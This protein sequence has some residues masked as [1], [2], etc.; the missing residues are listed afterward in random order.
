MTQSHPQ[1]HRLLLGAATGVFGLSLLYRLFRG[2]SPQGGQ[3][4]NTLDRI[5][6]LAEQIDPVAA[7]GTLLALVAIWVILRSNRTMAQARVAVQQAETARRHVTAGLEAIDIGI[8]LYDSDDRLVLCN[9]RYRAFLDLPDVSPQSG[10]SR[11]PLAKPTA[12]CDAATQRHE[13]RSGDGRWLQVDERPTSAG[14]RIR[15]LIDITGAKSREQTLAENQALFSAILAGMTQGV[16]VWNRSAQLVTCNHQFSALLNIPESLTTPGVGFHD[17]LALLDRCGD[18]G[19]PRLDDGLATWFDAPSPGRFKHKSCR[20][21]LVIETIVTPMPDGRVLA[22]HTDI[23]AFRHTE[24][25]LR[26]SDERFRQLSEATQGAVLVCRHGIVIDT[27]SAATSLFTQSQDALIGRDLTTL[28]AENGPATIVRALVNGAADQLEVLCRSGEGADFPAMASAK[29]MPFNGAPASVVVLRD[30]TAQR[31]T[32][33]ALREARDL[34]EM[35]NS[36]KSEF[37]ATM[38]HEI[39]TPLNGVLGMIGLLLDTKLDPEQRAY[40]STG[41]EAG[42]A[43]LTILNDILDAAKMD[44]GKLSLEN[45]DFDLVD[46]VECVADLLAVRASTK[47]IAL[48]VAVPATVPS[49]LRGDA[50]RIRQVLLNL[51]GNAVKF[52]E[53]GGVAI[54]VTPLSM[55]PDSAT[56]CFD[57]TDTGIGI[58]LAVQGRLFQDFVQADP[59][60]GRQYGGTGLG[61]AISRRLIDLMGGN[62]GFES[63]PDSGSRFWFVLRLQR[64][65]TAAPDPDPAPLNRV[66]ILLVDDNQTNSTVLTTQLQSWGATVTAANNLADLFGGRIVADA[67][68]TARRIKGQTIAILDDATITRSGPG[69]SAPGLAALLHDAGVE[70]LIL[71]TMVGRAVDWSYWQRIGFSAQVVKPAR[72]ASLLA[73]IRPH[74]VD[75]ARQPLRVTATTGEATEYR[76]LVVEDSPSNRLIAL[77]HLRNAGYHVDDA[78]DG[79]QAVAAAQRNHYDLILMDI[80]M[81]QMDGLQAAAALR[82]L[83]SPTGTVPIIAMTASAMPDDRAQC[84][85]AGMNDFIT[86][87]FDRNRMLNTV[88]HWLRPMPG[89]DGTTIDDGDRATPGIGES[90]VLSEE[91]LVLL[92]ENVDGAIVPRLIEQFVTEARDHAERLVA[93]VAAVPRDPDAIER[94]AHTLKSSAAT[95][96]ALQLADAAI[97]IEWSCRQATAPDLTEQARRIHRLCRATASALHRRPQPPGTDGVVAE[98]AS[99]AEI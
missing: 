4:A 9:K 22:T 33:D 64:Q 8:A 25:A 42:E 38:S 27:N 10:T 84:L 1:S 26:D 23:T 30:I 52:T 12:M 92:T 3:A 41:K 57:V 91:V 17:V 50:G 36:A 7:A 79:A 40:A 70:R 18:D 48:A 39:R 43:L 2:V 53:K 15:V 6:T 13:T 24:M 35:S 32:E 28:V 74:R 95:F 21:G 56:L 46:V 69:V 20:D 14:G 76:I 54:T 75:T 37:L 90:P 63:H 19:D 94:E 55:T 47:G 67:V 88:S 71:T 68:D 66:A 65:P 96:G 44:A 58:P 31:R 93:L 82:A 97:R 83:P 61:L 86:K 73:A 89:E 60:A 78:A 99:A 49:H 59:M 51:A 29:L 87:P 62:L 16:S 80:S 77:S 72:Q 11:E 5:M 45:N 98:P 81:P 85:A 34:S